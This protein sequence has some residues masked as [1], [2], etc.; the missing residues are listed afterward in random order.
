MVRELLH[1]SLVSIDFPKNFFRIEYFMLLIN[2]L[3]SLLLFGG[4][5]YVC[6]YRLLF[7]WE[8]VDLN[9]TAV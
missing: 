9:E 2:I 8:S 7:L 6:D 5:L 3:L 1:S 4:V